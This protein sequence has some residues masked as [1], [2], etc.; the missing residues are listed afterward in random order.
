MSINVFGKPDWL[1]YPSTVPS[2]LASPGL[3]SYLS[4]V[5]RGPSVVS[6]T[7]TARKAGRTC[8]AGILTDAMRGARIFVKALAR[9]INANRF[10]ADLTADFTRQHV[11]VDERRWRVVMWHGFG[12]CRVVEAHRHELLAGS[13][14]ERPLEYRR[15]LLACAVAGLHQPSQHQRREK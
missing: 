12:A 13:I 3:L 6:A 11:G 8:P 10:V 1:T 15:H 5:V 14:R 9:P 7:N 2:A 4:G